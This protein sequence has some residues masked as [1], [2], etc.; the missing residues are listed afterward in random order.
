[1]TGFSY[2]QEIL[3]KLV[4]LT[5]LWMVAALYVLDR[6][7]CL[8]LFFAGILACAAFEILRRGQGRLARILNAAFGITLRQEEKGAS[9]QPSGAVYVC[10]AALLCAFLF[11][12]EIAMSALAM[13]LTGDVAAAL[14]GRKFGKT[15]LLDKSLEGTAAFFI[16]A[17]PAALILQKLPGLT[18]LPA[19]AVIA[20]ALAAA[21]TELVSKKA[22]I[23]D[24]LA[25]P[26]AAGAVLWLLA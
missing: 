13:M 20:A 24:N 4:H 14:I 18:A 1:L 8:L 21:I 3:R 19:P 9:F 12:R 17:V 2:R 23:D 5:S 7:T 26:V 22:R 16:T 6:N 15:P 25:V 11:S 10:L